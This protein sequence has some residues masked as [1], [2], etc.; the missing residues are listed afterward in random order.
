MGFGLGSLRRGEGVGVG[1]EARENT[2]GRGTTQPGALGAREAASP[3]GASA[4]CQDWTQDGA[5]RTEREGRPRDGETLEQQWG[6]LCPLP[7]PGEE[8]HAGLSF[9]NLFIDF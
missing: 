3:E 1:G 8:T 5:M 2:W 4:V 9:L 6:L 7:P